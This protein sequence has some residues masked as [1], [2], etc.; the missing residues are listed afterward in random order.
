MLM[1]QGVVSGYGKVMINN[2]VNIEINQGEVVCIIGRN[3]VG[4]STFIKTLI[5]LNK[6]DKGKIE[7]DGMDI[8]RLKPYMRAELGIG[9]TPQGHGIFPNL[10]V[11]ENLTMGSMIN[12]KNKKL[13]YDLVYSY[14]PRL[15]QRRKQKAGTM[16]GG[17]QAMLSIGRVLVGNPKILL[18]DEPSEGV[19]PNI[20]MQIG[21]IIEKVCK[22]IG[23]TTLLVEQHMGLIQ[24]ISQRGYAMDKGSIIASLTPEQISDKDEI[25]K[26]LTI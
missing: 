21:E 3:G 15:A 14:F 24:Q 8:T 9:Y 18:L 22:E 26:F 25:N 7:F 6:C 20:V 10:T 12:T 17:E 23:L 4:K 11:A 16:S 19:Q 13:N 2:D 1:T 5:G